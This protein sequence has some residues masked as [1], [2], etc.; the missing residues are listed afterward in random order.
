M[1]T[2]RREALLKEYGEVATSFRALTDIRFRLLALLPIAAVAAAWLKGDAFGTNVTG[3]ALSTFG[4]A[5]TIGLVIYN[6]RNDQLYDELAGRAASIERSLGIPDGAFANRPTAWLKIH[7]VGIAVDVN[8]GTG[9]VVIY[10]ASVALWLTGLLA[11]IFEFGRVAYLGFGL[12]H[13]IVVSP[14][15]WTTVAAA[16]VATMTTTFVIGSI[17]TQTRSRRIEMRDLAVH[18]MTE[19]LS[20][21]VDLRLADED[22]PIVK[23]CATLANTKTDEVLRRARLY[24]STDADSLNWNVVSHS[25]FESASYIV[26]LL[27]NLPQRW[28]LECYVSRPNTALQPMAAAST[29][30]RRG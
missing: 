28:I 8:H 6:A 4:L 1:E 19:V 26:A 7:L 20:N 14:T 21:G 30:G 2:Q 25:R 17:G 12:P 9:V 24:F 13:L 10:A 11:P 3:M 22:S 27:T 18:A 15:S 16:A 23:S 5:A 29:T